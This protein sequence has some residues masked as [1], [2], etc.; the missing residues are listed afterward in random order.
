MSRERTPAGNISR[1]CPIERRSGE[2]VEED[3]TSYMPTSLDLDKLMPEDPPQA[4]ELSVDGETRSEPRRPPAKVNS[5]RAG[6]K[7]P[8]LMWT[9]GRSSESASP[10]T[11][12]TTC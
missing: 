2:D 5:G 3:A 10:F 11:S 7:G 9:W 1:P 12:T 8:K 4:Q 6:G